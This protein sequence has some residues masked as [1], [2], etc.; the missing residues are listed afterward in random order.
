[1]T[2]MSIRSPSTNSFLTKSLADSQHTAIWLGIFN[3][4]TNLQ[5]VIWS[6]YTAIEYSNFDNQTKATLESMAAKQTQADDICVY[7]DV[8]DHLTWKA[9]N[10]G[11]KLDFGCEIIGSSIHV[12]PA[13][14]QGVACPALLKMTSNHI[15]R[16]GIV[17]SNTNPERISGVY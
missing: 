16:E 11:Q 9:T 2:L 4:P 13:S 10:C 17:R 6:N 5:E 1:M 12:L 15:N 7:G 14:A 3:D 8:A